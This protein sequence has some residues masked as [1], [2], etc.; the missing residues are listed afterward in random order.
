MFSFGLCVSFDKSIIFIIKS[1]DLI[2]SLSYIF[3]IGYMP[4]P[5]LNNSNILDATSTPILVIENF[6]I[7]FT[8][9]IIKFIKP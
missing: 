9:I 5:I 6:F 2:I 1:F 7:V 4:K 8:Y 3:F